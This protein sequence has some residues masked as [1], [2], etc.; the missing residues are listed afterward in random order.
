MAF[1]KLPMEEALFA[2]RLENQ[3]LHAKVRLLA[4]GTD[5][6]ELAGV[7]LERDEECRAK[8][9]EI[10]LLTQQVGIMERRLEEHKG[11]QTE[12]EV[13]DLSSFTYR[14]FQFR[15]FCPDHHSRSTGTTNSAQRHGKVSSRRGGRTQDCKC[16]IDGQIG[17]H[18][19]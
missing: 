4:G 16:R 6:E 5:G 17:G 10:G 3:A 18:E 12:Y 9:T 2:L 7:I 14:Y 8:E 11:F 13:M 1:A 15:P 19:K